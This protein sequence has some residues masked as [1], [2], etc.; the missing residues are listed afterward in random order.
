MR[1]AVQALRSHARS[2][3][4]GANALRSASRPFAATNTGRILTQCHLS[5]VSASQK[6]TFVHY[7]AFSTTSVSRAQAETQYRQ[8]SY[9][10][11]AVED[12]DDIE[13]SGA[14]ERKIPERDISFAS[15]KP[16]MA[17]PT[18]KALTVKPFGYKDMSDV[19][20]KVLHLLPEL[21]DPQL[22]PMPDGQ[23]GRDM[24][25]KAKTGTGKTI[26]F[27][28]PAIERRVKGIHNAE[29]GLLTPSFAKMVNE[30]KP[31]FD[32]E[33]LDKHGR[34][35]LGR[36][37]ATNTVGTLVV[38]PTRE[39]ATQIAN[40]AVKLHYHHD[41]FGVQLLVGGASRTHQ[42]NDWRRSR[43]D[44]VVA[45]P[46]RL[47]DL[48]ETD[49]M[50]REALSA[51]QTLVLDEA[52]QLLELGFR[53]EIEKLMRFIPKVNERVTMLFSAT[54]GKDIRQVARLSLAK[55]ARLIDCVPEGENNFHQNIPQTVTTLESSADLFPHISRLIAL[56]QLQNAGKS[57]IIVFANTTKYVELVA[58]L[59]KDREV[60]QS[61]PAGVK[62]QFY[63]IHSKKE[64]STR[65]NISSTF[66]QDQS[67]A[68]VLFTSDLSARGVDYPGCTRVIQ[69][70]A[71][72]TQDQYIHRLGR[73]GRA[74]K[75][76]RSDLVL[77]PFES[78][79]RQFELREMPIN[80]G[81]V[82]ETTQELMEIASQ[83]DADPTS[84]VDAETWKAMENSSDGG[85]ASS[86][87]GG[88][89]KGRQS[90]QAP[91]ATLQVPIAPK[92][93]S[94]EKAIVAS[95]QAMPP[96]VVSEVFASSCGFYA[97]APWL[98]SDK[99]SIVDGLQEWATG[100]GCMERAPFVS[101]KF[102][103]MLGISSSGGGG[104]RG[105]GGRG[106]YSKDDGGGRGGYSRGGGGRG[107][108]SRDDRDGG[109]GFSRGRS[110]RGR[111]GF[112]GSRGGGRFDAERSE[113]GRSSYGGGSYGGGGY[114][115]GGYSGG[116]GGEEDGG[117]YRGDRG[118]RRGG[119]GGG[120]RGSRGGGFRGS[121]GGDR[122][123][124]RGFDGDRD[125]SSRGAS[126]IEFS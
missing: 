6:H 104:G 8:Q 114:G 97:G 112:G 51:T 98:R 105:G 44:V 99:G 75:G 110:D 27:L 116:R 55:D 35:A 37:F 90:R 63:E 100:A 32:F 77:L 25:V 58:D 36:Q 94:L 60:K 42:L 47:L 83:F 1:L 18:W 56:D 120:F 89:N 50:V 84:V 26:A 122:G 72:K 117:G 62:T 107:G 15:L 78:P 64:Q 12:I 96:E 95:M 66:R 41:K 28:V 124:F 59:F 24:L 103:Q 14:S 68:S 91:L 115:G 11:N 76:G 45:T 119:R 88:R 43:P 17:Y 101:A 20:N 109:G 123:G 73:T 69:V 9:D 16:H 40:E 4:L 61:L 19:Q 82:E 111:G 81:T 3:C 34:I 13:E 53:E 65:F 87:R 57:K 49:P 29:R 93:E 31:D 7:K 46:G 52:D 30:H 38:S 5:S 125:A 70:G 102:A 79:F 74:G 126:Q 2:S 21:A 113:G 92:V 71:P 23:G 67:G 48:A 106:S 121:R 86:F 108:Y 85:Y 80:D 10:E 33:S 39:L 54:I 118:D 22:P